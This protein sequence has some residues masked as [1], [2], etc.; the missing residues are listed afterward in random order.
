MKSAIA[1]AKVATAS[2]KAN[3]GVE[4][5]MIKSSPFN[6]TKRPLRRP[7]YSRE[8]KPTQ[9]PRQ[10]AAYQEHL[11][12]DSGSSTLRTPYNPTGRQTSQSGESVQSQAR[13]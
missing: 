7:P 5:Q 12:A 11:I 13:R 9:S 8:T 3:R 6:Q 10:I 4:C 2:E 1:E